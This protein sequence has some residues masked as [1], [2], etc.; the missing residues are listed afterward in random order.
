MKLGN[1]RPEFVEHLIVALTAIVTTA[2]FLLITDIL[3]PV[4]CP[5]SLAL[6]LG[7]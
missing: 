4:G 2:L 7:L 5:G 3:S 1:V 6:C